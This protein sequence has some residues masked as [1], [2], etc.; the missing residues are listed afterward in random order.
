MSFI[1]MSQLN[2]EQIDAIQDDSNIFLI[3]APGSGKTR[4]LTYKI[5]KEL[6]ELDEKNK[7]IV[8]ITYTNRAAE[9]IKERIEL[10][11]I[12]TNKL[13]VG[14]IH[15]FCIE[16]ILKPYGVFNDKLKYGY[17]IINSYESEE[18]ISQICTSFSH[19]PCPI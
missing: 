16:W 10:L 13:W 12:D 1:D 19:Q 15:A 14:T 17:N 11:G 6:S 9:E 18:I 3:A 4:A 2:D 5:A 7:W 8:A